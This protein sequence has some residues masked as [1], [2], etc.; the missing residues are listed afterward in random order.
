MSKSNEGFKMWN[1]KMPIIY[2]VLL[3][4]IIWVFTTILALQGY[5][6]GPNLRVCS[7][8]CKDGRRLHVHQ[9]PVSPRRYATTSCKECKSYLCYFLC[10]LGVGLVETF[11][12]PGFY[13]T[14]KAVYF[15]LISH[16]N[17]F[18]I[19]FFSFITCSL[20]C[21]SSGSP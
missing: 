14:F 13:L 8:T 18:F 1:I 11:V 17:I 20:P 2:F 19:Y 15:F 10:I 12:S 7:G 21:S 5:I 9:A 4:I 6:L 3:S 16:I